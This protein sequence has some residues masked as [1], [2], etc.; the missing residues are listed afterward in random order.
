MS[1]VPPAKQLKDLK[2]Q[3]E[4]SIRYH[5]RRQAF[6]ES[7]DTTVNAL[8]LIL[9]SGAVLTL[10][11][12]QFENWFATLL[13]ALVAVISFINLAARSAEKG[14][15]HSQLKQRY[16]DLLKRVRKIDAGAANF[17]SSF[18]RCEDKLLD[19][20]GEEPPINRLVDLMA[21]NELALSQG[22]SNDYIYYIHPFKALTANLWRYEV[23]QPETMTE[24][25]RQ[26]AEAAKR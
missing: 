2:F 15:I 9:G 5:A 8:N 21:N 4:R 23:S 14:A 22:E 26:V 11:S 20:E 13:A 24:H 7:F 19:I 6:F 1:A 10:I 17:A 18:A 3:V 25:L 12:A 16:N